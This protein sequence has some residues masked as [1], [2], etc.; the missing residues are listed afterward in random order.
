MKQPTAGIILAAGE[1]L[2][3][4]RPKLLAPLKGKRLIEWVLDSCLQSKLQHILLVL[5]HRHRA[6]L[7]AL[8]QRTQHPR[9][10]ITVNS[11]YREGQSTSLCAGL[12]AAGHEFNS[13]MFV[14]GDQP[15]VT[16]GLIDTLLEKFWESP[17]QMC[18]PVCKGRRGNP[19]LFSRRFYKSIL[20]LQGDV[21]ARK[22][23]EANPE[24]VLKVEIGDPLFFFD[25][26]TAAD[27]QTLESRILA[28]RAGENLVDL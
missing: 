6:I 7:Q 4:G 23:I 2:R 9:L 21:G 25:V 27:L 19:A 1:S 3:F 26:D 18:V 14:L 20:A 28:A 16:A 13:V 5:G 24:E 11:R 8:G 22:I 10:T 12:L 17:R 15:I